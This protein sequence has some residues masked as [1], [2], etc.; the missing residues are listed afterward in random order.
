MHRIEL[1]SNTATDCFQELL[2]LL[3]RPSGLPKEMSEH[4]KVVVLIDEYDQP[5]TRHL[6]DEYLK[7]MRVTLHDVYQVMKK[8][9]EHIRFIF[10]TGVSKFSGLSVFSALNNPQD[11]TLRPKIFHCCFKQDT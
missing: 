8:C 2:T 1:K 3:H 9:D 5:V 10:I 11:I 4:E 7:P 6:H